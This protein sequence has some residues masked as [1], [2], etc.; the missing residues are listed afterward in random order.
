MNQRLPLL[1]ITTLLCM[2]LLSACSDDP[3]SANNEPPA[4][5]SEASMEMDLSTLLGGSQKTQAATSQEINYYIQAVYKAGALEGVIESNLS[6]PKQLLAAA[7]DTIA[8]LNDEQRWEW[9][10]QHTIS[11]NQYQVRLVAEQIAAATVNWSLFVTEDSLNIENRLYFSGTTTEEGQK[12]LWAFN[13]LDNT[14]NSDPVAELD[15]ELYEDSTRLTLDIV[16]DENGSAGSYID[17]GSEGPV[18]TIE[19]YNADNEQTNTI[20]WNADT[21]AGYIIVPDVNSGEQA[22]WDEELQDTSCSE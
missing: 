18:K 2:F 11:D 16:A 15:W 20:Q 9:D 4:L 5:P 17:Y 1:S 19:Y 3:S 10:Y 13:S 14:E 6:R 7:R 21:R 22:C 12:G 8:E